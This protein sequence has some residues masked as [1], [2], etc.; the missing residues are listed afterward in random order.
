MR[1]GAVGTYY[2][3]MP[4]WGP[5]AVGRQGVKAAALCGRRSEPAFHMRIWDMAAYQSDQRLPGALGYGSVTA[6]ET[7][8]MTSQRHNK[9]KGSLKDLFNKTPTKKAPP[10]EPPVTEGGELVDQGTQGDRE[11]PLTRSFMEQL[12]GSPRGDFATL[13]QEIAVE[14]TELKQEVADLGQR[15]DTLEQACDA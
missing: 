15:V 14:V 12:F 4:A 10:V 1:K 8:A 11:A 13:K 2:G 5:E 9:K 7:V 6:H 3:P